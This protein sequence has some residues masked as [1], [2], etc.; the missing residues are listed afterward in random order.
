MDK[1]SFTPDPELFAIYN[2]LGYLQDGIYFKEPDCT[3]CLK[4]L[5][6]FMRTENPNT[7]AT[8]RQLGK[9]IN[10]HW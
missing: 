1:Q 5:L 6:K 2:S 10:Y 4:D 8:R 3:A 9:T 7:F